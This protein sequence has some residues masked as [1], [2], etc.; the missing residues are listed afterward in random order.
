M[1]TKSTRPKPPPHLTP[2]A[3][4]LWREIVDG[5]ELEGHHLRILEVALTAMDRGAAARAVIDKEGAV[6]PDRFGQPKP[7][8]EVAIERDAAITFMRGLRELGLDSAALDE[9]PRPPALR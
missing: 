1:T 7:R 4:R 6:F 5:F 3:R 2:R 9:A 8:P